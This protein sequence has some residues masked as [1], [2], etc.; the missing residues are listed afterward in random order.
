MAKNDY[1]V[2]IDIKTRPHSSSF[3]TKASHTQIEF[4]MFSTPF[5]CGEF[6]RIGEEF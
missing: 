2:K 4:S 1:Y 6:Q 5:R 3:S